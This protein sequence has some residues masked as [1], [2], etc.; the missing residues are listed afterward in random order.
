[1]QKKVAIVLDDGFHDL[2]LWIPYYRLKEEKIEFD[3][4]AW[5][6]RAYKGEFGIDSVLP[7]RLLSEPLED[8][9]LAFFPGARS[10]ENL[11]KN[12]ESAKIVRRM[13]DRGTHLATI[14]HSPLLLGEAGLLKG[15]SVTGHFSIRQAIEKFGANYVDAPVVKSSDNIFTGRTHLDMAQ[16]M[17]NLMKEI[18]SL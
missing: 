5:Q 6:N 10:P 17:P 18:L 2:E 7:T 15:K 16:F 4:L 14:C 9:C 13:Y 8:Y 3:I 1:M 12:S 11:L